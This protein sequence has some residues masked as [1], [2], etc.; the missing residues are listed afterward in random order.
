MSEAIHFVPDFSIRYAPCACVCSSPIWNYYCMP[1]NSGSRSTSAR[2]LQTAMNVNCTYTCCRSLTRLDCLAEI[3]LP[4]PPLLSPPLHLSLPASLAFPLAHASECVWAIRSMSLARACTTDHRDPMKSRK[5][6]HQTAT[7]AHLKIW[8]LI[9]IP[10]A[11][12]ACMLRRANVR[13]I[14]V[15]PYVR[16]SR[17]CENT[18]AY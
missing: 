14:F 3:R 8:Q 4:P 5:P 12:F 1:T 2:K 7:K 13:G 11:N 9:S 18:R 16:V 15:C 17:V 10:L 6:K